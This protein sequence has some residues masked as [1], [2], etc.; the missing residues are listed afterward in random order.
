MITLRGYFCRQVEMLLGRGKS[1]TAQNYHSAWRMVSKYLGSQA[2]VFRLSAIT[3]E[4]VRGYVEWLFAR[5]NLKPGSINYYFRCLC[6]LYRRAVKER[7]ISPVRDPFTGLRPTVPPTCKRTLSEEDLCK[8]VGYSTRPGVRKTRSQAC[9]VFLFLFY[10]RGM[11][12]VDVYNLKKS[13]INGDYICYSRS[14][15]EAPLQ[16]KIIPEVRALI[17]KYADAESDYLFP[18]L[19]ENRRGEGEVSEKSA[20]RRLNRG[21]EQVGKELGITQILTTYV[22]RHTWAS[23]VES[24]GMNTAVIS[25]GLGHGSERVT[26]IYMKGMPSLVIDKANEEMLNQTVRLRRKRKKERGNLKNKEEEEKKKKKCHLLS[27][28]GTLHRIRL[29]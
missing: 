13:N 22:A 16:V 25:Q 24:C 23:M 4:W 11:C 12:F 18:F 19:R 10:T 8:I 6:A 20:L 21:L 5:G 26:R 1:V 28:K 15:T 14:K 9:D 2:A 7:I 29:I 17:D 27:K 3:E